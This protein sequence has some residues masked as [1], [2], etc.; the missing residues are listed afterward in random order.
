MLKII[1]G[2]THTL[3]VENEEMSDS[4][5]VFAL[6]AQCM[7]GVQVQIAMVADSSYDTNFASLVSSG[8]KVVTVPNTTGA[9]YIHAKAVVADY[10]L[11]G[12]AAYMGSINYSTASISQNRELGIFI[13]DQPSIDQ[14]YQVMQADFSNPLATPYP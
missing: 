5:I 8:C 4:T 2:A 11:A 3:I 6:Q 9:F 1:D 13:Q 10:G 14:L 12:Q 7:L